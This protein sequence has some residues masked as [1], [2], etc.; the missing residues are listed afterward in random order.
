MSI[1]DYSGDVVSYVY[2]QY[3]PTAMS[4]FAQSDVVVAGT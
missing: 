4:V 1:D 2:Q 3:V